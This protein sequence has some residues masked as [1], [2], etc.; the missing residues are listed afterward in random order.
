MISRLAVVIFV[1]IIVST[2]AALPRPGF[3]VGVQRRT[4]DVVQNGLGMI[5][6]ALL[7][8]H[9]IFRGCVCCPFRELAC[10]CF[11]VCSVHCICSERAVVSENPRWNVSLSYALFGFAVSH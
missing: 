2:A 3:N 1:G 9:S 8:L 5:C 11:C 7:G 6:N 10:V 4:S